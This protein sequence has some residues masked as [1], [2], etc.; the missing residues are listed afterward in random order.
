MSDSEVHLMRTIFD[1]G[2][3]NGEDLS[4]YLKKADRV[5]AIEANPVLCTRMSN[6]YGEF[7]EHGRLSVEN[8]AL[9]GEQDYTDPEINFYIHKEFH[10][11]SQLPRPDAAGMRQ[12]DCVSVPAKTLK[13][14]LRKYWIPFY[15]KIDIERYDQVILRDLFRLNCIPTYISAEIQSLEVVDLLLSRS[16]YTGFKLVAGET[17]GQLYDDISIETIEGTNER[18]A[19]PTHSAGPFGNDVRGP[20]LDNVSM[21][22][23]IMKTGLGW[24]DLHA[25]RLDAG[26]AVEIVV[27]TVARLRHLRARVAANLPVPVKRAIKKLIAVH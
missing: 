10:E 22:H 1:I 20:W 4:Y 3:N 2:A 21:W 9:V 19:F 27:P 12:F 23:L 13:Q 25:S 16:E 18:Y 6:R 5:V 26:E 14:I 7:I 24:Y 15:I 11:L 17:V 8:C